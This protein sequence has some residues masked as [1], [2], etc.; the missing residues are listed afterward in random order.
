MAS[1][2]CAPV[3]SSPPASTFEY[4][5]NIDRVLNSV[6]KKDRMTL[7]KPLRILDGYKTEIEGKLAIHIGSV[8]P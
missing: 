2:P 3:C 4:Y 6:S 8:Y 7:F 1:H 5:D